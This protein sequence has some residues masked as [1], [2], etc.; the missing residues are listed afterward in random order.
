[1]T[2]LEPI[3]HRYSSCALLCIEQHWISF[4]I[5]LLSLSISSICNYLSAPS[6]SGL[7]ILNKFML[8]Q[9]LS[10]HYSLLFPDHSWIPWS[11]PVPWYPF[12][13]LHCI[14]T[15]FN[16]GHCKV[17]TFSNQVLICKI[18]YL[19]SQWHC[20]LPRYDYL[21]LF[22]FTPVTLFHLPR[23]SWKS[24]HFLSH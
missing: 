12:T 9:T 6:T 20:A 24:K 10:L 23:T 3:L 1:M 15:S 21:H 17:M 16:N 14:V 11:A 18:F 8:M 5:L 2:H 7:S 13:L 19:I 4:T 22:F